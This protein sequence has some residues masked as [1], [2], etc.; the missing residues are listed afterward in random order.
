MIAIRDG[1]QVRLRVHQEP[2]ENSCRPAVDVLLRSVAQ[3][4]GPNGYTFRSTIKEE[5]DRVI[6]TPQE[7]AAYVHV[8]D[9][10]LV[11]VAVVVLG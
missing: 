3:V 11:V 7:K 1:L 6:H 5:E 9:P 8:E 2:P 10:D 4:F